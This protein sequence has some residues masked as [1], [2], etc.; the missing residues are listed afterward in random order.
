LKDNADSLLNEARNEKTKKKIFL[1]FFPLLFSYFTLISFSSPVGSSADDNYHLPSI[2]CSNQ[3]NS[4]ICKKNG[5][6]YF[7]PPEINGS[8]FGCYIIWVDKKVSRY[9]ISAKC[10]DNPRS[11]D[12]LAETE[13]LNQRNKLYPPVFYEIS[14]I[15]V[16]ND[17]SKSVLQIRIFWGGF[18]TIFLM[19]AFY[20]LPEKLRYRIILMLSAVISPVFAFVVS[21]TNPSSGAFISLFFA[22]IFM[23]ILLTSQTKF[24]SISS[25]IVFSILVI[26]GGG[27]RADAGIFLILI[28][29]AMCILYREKIKDV[30]IL[31]TILTN[32]IFVVYF[33]SLSRQF[34][35]STNGMSG[36]STLFPFNTELFYYNL[37]R[38]P[39][40]FAGFWGYHWGLGWKF[41]PP[42]NNFYTLIASFASIFFLLKIFF[43]LSVKVKK[44]IVALFLF[45]LIIP[46]AMFQNSNVLVGDSIQPRYMFPLAVGIMNL[47]A[48]SSFSFPAF[49]TTLKKQLFCLVPV[50]LFFASSIS[51][52]YIM[53]QRNV[54]GLAGRPFSTID[55]NSWWWQNFPVSPST[56]FLFHIIATICLSFIFFQ[57]FKEA[58]RDAPTVIGQ[59]KKR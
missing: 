42:L 37:I 10:I 1:L 25:A 28:I 31:T 57:A 54:N 14:R 24:H 55:S 16:D 53:L 21:S 49:S 19:F 43:E 47:I 18:F 20:M 46:L 7:V 6:K 36:T 22:P 56:I 32:L 27:S 51:T 5:N 58:S 23:H 40:Y 52:S 15:F 26:L 50:F 35:A 39:E 4:D 9:N 59:I 12:R 30:F 2:W 45:L 38:L 33:L 13:F 34:S 41:E 11:K 48:V 3:D 29:V 44:Y 8:T 17:Y